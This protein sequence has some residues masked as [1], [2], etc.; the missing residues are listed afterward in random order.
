[1]ALPLGM[2][3]LTWRFLQ[4]TWQILTGKLDRLIAGHE[5]EEEIEA[6]KEE[7]KQAS[8]ALEPKMNRDKGE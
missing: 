4:V 6:M 3:L 5:V 1:M 8:K 2:A 7:L